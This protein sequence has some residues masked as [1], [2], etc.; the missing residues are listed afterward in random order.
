MFFTFSLLI[1]SN[2][3]RISMTLPEKYQSFYVD[4]ISGSTSAQLVHSSGAAS[5]FRFGKEVWILLLLLL[6]HY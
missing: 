4:S 2:M 3:L 6:L 5:V 1:P